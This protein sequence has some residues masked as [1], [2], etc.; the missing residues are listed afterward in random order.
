MRISTVIDPA[1]GGG[2]PAGRSAPFGARGVTGLLE[3]DVTLGVARRVATHLGGEA[4]LTRQAD[5]NL[6]LGERALAAGQV[7]ARAFISLHAGA[8][9]NRPEI[10]VHTRSSTRSA[11]LADN[12]SRELACFGAR[13]RRGDLAVLHPNVHPLEQAACVVELGGLGQV[14]GERRLRDANH[15]EVVAQA[16]TRGV[17]GFL[18]L[19]QRAYGYVARG[20]ELDLTDFDESQFNVYPD[21]QTA[22]FPARVTRAELD[23]IKGSWDRM[24]RATGLE[25]NGSDADLRA[26]RKKLCDCMVT[27]KVVRDAFLGI[28]ADDGF[29]VSMDIG[30]GQPRVFVDAF[31]FSGNASPPTTGR[32]R[33]TIDLTDFDKFPRVSTTE[34]HYMMTL[35]ENLI[36][37]LVEAAAGVRSPISAATPAIPDPDRARF[38]A[39]HFHA[40]DEE[41]RYRSEQGMHGMLDHF[42]PVESD[43]GATLTWHLQEGASDAA[44]ETWHLT[45]G[46]SGVLDVLTSLDYNL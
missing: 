38:L 23:S 13:V 10:W 33:H 16:I 5:V 1:H 37:A 39:S 3:K 4:R 25:L 26:F 11:A 43:A 20:L 19:G 44:M 46:P 41:N 35:S 27:S 14:E 34:H 7:G 8:G 31:E 9:A 21:D 24:M 32:G 40:I 15:L 18:G 30:R 6:S 45:R 28:A 22:G 36:H 42:Q 12:L 17:R 2:T 29:K